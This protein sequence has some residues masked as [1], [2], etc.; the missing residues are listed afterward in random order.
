MDHHLSSGASG[1]IDGWE[2]KYYYGNRP[3]GVYIPR[4]TN[5][6][7]DKRDFVRGFGYQGRA[8]RN[9]GIPSDLSFG[10][11]FKE[12]LTI[13]GQWNMGIGGFGET[14]PDETNLMRLTER[15]DQWGLP[16]IEFDA[17]WGDNEQKMR[18]AM[19]D[20]A[21][22]MLEA[23]G[24]YDVNGYK[25]EEKSPGIGIHEMGT[26]RMG[27]KEDNSVLNKNNQ[28]WGAE[29]VF[30]TDGAAMTSSSCVN[31]SLT[32]MALT[33]RAAAFAVDELKKMNM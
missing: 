3:N 14:L 16:I 28:V 5:W 22:A 8:S 21:V 33:A 25:D 32:Y 24:F 9:K 26:A 4:F 10:A 18:V 30:V 23:A 17:W 27:T 20:E 1:V 29:N 7:N 15:K 12:S 19:R 13:P 31:P 11:E 2:D 6:G